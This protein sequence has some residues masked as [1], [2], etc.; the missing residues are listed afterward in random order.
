[1]MRALGYVTAITMAVAGTALGVMA[2]RAL[3]DA[4]RYVAMRKM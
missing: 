3:P 4:R 2:V 1:M